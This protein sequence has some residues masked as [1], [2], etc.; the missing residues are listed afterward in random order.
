MRGSKLIPRSQLYKIL[1]ALVLGLSFG[2]STAAVEESPVIKLE[3]LG[4][5][6][7]IR[8]DTKNLSSLEIIRAPIAPSR[9][10]KN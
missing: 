3:V 8:A 9:P 7:V 6:V 5:I 2:Q 10:P 4:F 1:P